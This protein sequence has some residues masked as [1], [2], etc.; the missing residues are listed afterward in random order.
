MGFDHEQE[1]D[2]EGS[3]W[4]TQHGIGEGLLAVA[5]FVVVPVGD[6]QAALHF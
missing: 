4:M 2:Y 5:G 3:I 6:L 1:H